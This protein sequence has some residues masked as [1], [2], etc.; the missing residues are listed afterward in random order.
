MT[1]RA[2]EALFHSIGEDLEDADVL[3]LYAGSG[4]LGIEALS[5]GA[6]SAVFV[7]KAGPALIAIR[8]NL[9]ATRLSGQVV[10]TDVAIFL[11]RNAGPFD[12][13]FLD[14][15]FP[16]ATEDLEPLVWLATE[17]LAPG[18]L[19]VVTRRSKDPLPRPRGGLRLAW[20]RKYGDTR[21]GRYV[22]DQ[23]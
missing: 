2:K 12:V 22:K 16:M 11:Q 19:M 14:P 6:A 8:D 1:D 15:P 4:S 13:I 5:R 10:A 3:D 17:K 23:L 20:D 7:E 21:I 9:A 18:G